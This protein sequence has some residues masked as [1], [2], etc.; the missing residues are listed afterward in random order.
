MGKIKIAFFIDTLAAG[1]AQNHVINLMKYIDRSRFDV[2]VVCTHSKGSR[3]DLIKDSNIPS[4]ICNL[5]NLM[6][7]LKT[8]KAAYDVS[9]FLKQHDIQIIHSY[10]FN[11]IL[12][13][14]LTKFFFYRKALLF[15]SRRDTGF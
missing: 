5:E 10:M 2:V 1:G 11:P 13:S 6:K 8:F 14:F 9:K 3:F 12:F 7:P 4:Y 15:T